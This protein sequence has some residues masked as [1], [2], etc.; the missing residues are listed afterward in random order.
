MRGAAN[1][2]SAEH[3][4]TV[5][6]RR[7]AGAHWFL[8]DSP[9]G[10]WLRLH[11]PMRC[12]SVP[13]ICAVRHPLVWIGRSMRAWEWAFLIP[14]VVPAAPVAR[15]RVILP[16]SEK[17]LLLLGF[18]VCD[19]TFNGFLRGNQCRHGSCRQ[20]FPKRSRGPSEIHVTNF[21]MK[22]SNR[23]KLSK[24]KLMLSVWCEPCLQLCHF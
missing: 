11:K 2:A 23:H 19:L 22:N 6:L 12:A 9:K 8:S 15:N 3:S 21:V 17:C 7:C 4:A 13:F 5:R 14:M 1:V 16:E 10:L 24:P 20:P 18:S